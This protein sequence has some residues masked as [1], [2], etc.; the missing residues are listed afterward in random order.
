[1]EIKKIFY[2]IQYIQIVPF[3]HVVNIEIVEVAYI[4]FHMKS[5][6]FSVYF[7][8]AAHLDLD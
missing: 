8:F 1:M 4:F 2:L 6:K 7:I 3:Q 5:S